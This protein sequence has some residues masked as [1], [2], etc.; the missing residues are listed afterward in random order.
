MTPR[1]SLY[2][3][4][5]HTISFQTHYFRSCGAFGVAL[6]RVSKFRVP[7]FDLQAPV[8]QTLSSY[9]MGKESIFQEI[10][11]VTSKPTVSEC[12][13]GRG[14]VGLCFYDMP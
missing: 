9:R 1:V 13:I 6:Y 10:L 12:T 3:C 4:N 5:H 2:R 7:F 8:G 11:F 14:G